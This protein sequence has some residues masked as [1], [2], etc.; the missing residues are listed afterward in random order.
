MKKVIWN[1][2]PPLNEDRQEFASIYYAD[3]IYVF[4]GY[5]IKKQSNLSSIERINVNS[6]DKFEIVYINEQISIKCL[7]CAK[8]ID[9]NEV[10]DNKECILL[11]G[12]LNG[13]NYIDCSLA[14]NLNEMKIRDCEVIIPNINKHCQF[15]FQKES[16]FVEVEPGIQA[17]FDKNNNVHLLTKKSY[18]LF[19]AKE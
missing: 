16:G 6:N 19:T 12:G 8:F 7:G 1:S 3:Y 11:L 14:L 10:G 5:S 2:L 9:E 4:F 18:E 17:I 15:L 13:E